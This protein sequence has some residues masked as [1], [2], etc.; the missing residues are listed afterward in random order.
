MLNT[1]YTKHPAV[2]CRRIADEVILV[3]ISRNVG[4]IDC[5]YVL[6]DVG[7]R[8]WNLLDRRS[9]TEVRDAII[10]EF[11]V[12]E[13]IAQQDLT[14]LIDQLKEIGAIQEVS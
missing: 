11:D 8:I 9:L 5:L 1:L 2:V 4:D 12:S 13:A 3:P 6:N 14:A 7:A 10:E